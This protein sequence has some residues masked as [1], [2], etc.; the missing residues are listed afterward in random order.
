VTGLRL[1]YVLY[2]VG[3][4]VKYL[5]FLVHP[6]RLYYTRLTRSG[7]GGVPRYGVY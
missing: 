3:G 5:G 4:V 6:P 2:Y 1:K 7:V